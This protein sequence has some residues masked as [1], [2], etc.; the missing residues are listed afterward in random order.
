MIG[1]LRGRV[2][3]RLPNGAVV[4]DVGG[5]GYE[6]HV[7]SSDPPKLNDVVEL[8]IYTAVR[9]DAIVLYGFA[10]FD[11]RSFFTMLLATPGVGPATALTALRTMTMAELAAAI[12]TGDHHRVAMVPGIGAKTASRIVLELHG[13][14]D[15]D[16]RSGAG[17]PAVPSVIEE[18]LRRL[19]YDAGE[20]RTLADVELP[21]DDGEALRVAL[22]HLG[23]T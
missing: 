14:I 18:A 19:G 7:A 20:I 10:S 23:G 6:V 12:E 3:A 17:A 8:A 13:K 21:S 1:S 4:V 2:H 22:R 9:S 16:D 15:L 5:V 11:E